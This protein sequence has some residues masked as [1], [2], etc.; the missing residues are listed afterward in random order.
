MGTKVYVQ[1]VTT[2][3]WDKVGQ[4]VG[5]GEKRSYR[6]KMPSG[7]TFWRN[8]RFLRPWKGSGDEDGRKECERIDDEDRGKIED[9]DTS[10][11]AKE[12]NPKPIL[13]RSERIQKSK[14]ATGE[15]K[16]IRFG[17]NTVKLFC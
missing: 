5:V 9:E 10:M 8:R 3:L 11:P 2:K 16:K 4:I 17:I 15:K 13:R 14:I 6:V 1:D 7:R 12:M